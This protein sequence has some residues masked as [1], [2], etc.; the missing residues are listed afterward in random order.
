M[1]K[2][3]VTGLVVGGIAA[4][5]V[6]A[7]A[8]YK[9][10]NRGPEYAQVVKVTPLMRTVHTPRQACHDETVTRQKPVQDQHQMIGTVAGAVLGGVLGNQVGHGAGRDIATVAGAAAGGYAGNRVQKHVQDNDTYTTTEQQ[11]NT[12]YDSAQKATGRYEVR[13][14]LGDQEHTIRMD[15]DPGDRLPVHDGK[16]VTDSTAPRG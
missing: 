16:V 13:Y 6:G 2:S 10:L 1:D 9:V 12:V 3:L 14:R 15:H 5:A 7:F 8:S 11:C 4:T